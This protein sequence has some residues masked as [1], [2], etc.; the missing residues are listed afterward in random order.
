[1]PQLSGFELYKEIKKENNNNNNNNKKLK[2]CHITAYEIDYEVL[3]GKFPTSHMDCFIK[4][5][6][7]IQ[8][9]IKR[10]RA[11]LG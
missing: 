6:F 11:E 1:M 9:L 2:V 4:K 5:L 7:Q 8:D 10:V 3:R